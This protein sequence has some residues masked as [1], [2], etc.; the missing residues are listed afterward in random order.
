MI[1]LDEN[2]KVQRALYLDDDDGG[3][4][5]LYPMSLELTGMGYQNSANQYTIECFFRYN[6]NYRKHVLATRNHCLVYDVKE[7]RLEKWL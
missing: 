2:A 6:S 7:Q 3:F 1:Y 4:I 5:E